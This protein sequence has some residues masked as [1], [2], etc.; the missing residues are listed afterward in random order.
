VIGGN[1]QLLYDR[2]SDGDFLDA[3]ESQSLPG[4]GTSMGCDLG[5]SALTGRLLIVHNPDSE[6]RLLVDLND[7]GDFADPAEN[8][9]LG[10]PF[11]APLAVASTSTGGV[12]VLTPQGV[13]SGPVR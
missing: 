9:A 13:V 4:T 11:S 6:L 12:R 10:A 7:D 3:N 8:A 5:T 2:N 1:P